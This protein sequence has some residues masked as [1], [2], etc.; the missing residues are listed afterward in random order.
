MKGGKGNIPVEAR[1][2]RIVCYVKEAA[3]AKTVFA[4]YVQGSKESSV[5]FH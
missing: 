2:N 4:L 3:L 5:S 1:D